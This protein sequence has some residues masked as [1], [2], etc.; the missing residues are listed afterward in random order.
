M[1]MPAIFRHHAA[2]YWQLRVLIEH[3]VDGTTAAPADHSLSRIL[4]ATTWE[5]HRLAAW[6]AAKDKPHG[7]QGFGVTW[8]MNGKV[9]YR[10]NHIPVCRNGIPGF[11]I[12]KF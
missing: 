1:D 4:T 2:A 10:L 5:S 11:F 9:Q 8:T 7:I 6:D 3:L 12:L